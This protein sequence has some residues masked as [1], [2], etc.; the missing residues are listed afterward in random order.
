MRIFIAGGSGVLG[1]P[2]VRDLVRLGHT[3]TATTHTRDRMPLIERLGAEAV[4]MDA[5]DTDVVH[6][7]VTRARPQVLINQLTS[8]STPSPDYGEW[9]RLTNRLR[10]EASRTLMA[11]ARE[12]GAT[13]VIAQSASFM[14]SPDGTAPTD[15]SSPLYTSAPEPIRGH[16]QANIALENVVTGTSGVDGVVLRY[17]FLYGRGTGFGPGGDFA[18]AVQAG[19]LPIVGEG[20]GHFAFVHIQDAV[21]AAVLAVDRGSAGIY[22]V[23]DDDPAPQAIWLPY[24]AELLHGPAPARISEAEAAER[25]GVQAVYNGNQLLPAVNVKAKSH[26]GLALRYPSWRQGFQEVFS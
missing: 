26:L 21:A 3:V 12:A 11:A 7:A 5:F 18:N 6:H 2:L 15:E 8:L 4:L 16:V 20:A 24:L 17:G 13:R 10:S 1:R 9:L 22:N 25:I 19:Q 14:T 23:I